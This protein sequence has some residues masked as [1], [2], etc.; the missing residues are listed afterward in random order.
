MASDIT[1]RMRLSVTSP[2]DNDTDILIE[3][4]GLKQMSLEPSRQKQYKILISDNLYIYIYNAYLKIKIL[5][6]KA[7]RTKRSNQSL[8]G[9][10]EIRVCINITTASIRGFIYSHKYWIMLK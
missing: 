7:M 9:F 8:N 10:V 2:M 6:E 5:I 4:N 3:D 1:W